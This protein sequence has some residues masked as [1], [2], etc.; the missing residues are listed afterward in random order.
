MLPL[1]CFGI[2][3]ILFTKF[4]S[5]YEFSYVSIFFTLLWLLF[6]IQDLKSYRRNKNDY[7]PFEKRGFVSKVKTFALSSIS[8]L[9]F[10]AVCFAEINRVPALIYTIYKGTHHDL[11]IDV[12]KTNPGGKGSCSGTSKLKFEFT[13]YDPFFGYCLSDDK[14]EMFPDKNSSATFDVIESPVGILFYDV[15]RTAS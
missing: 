12:V 4:L 6:L 9:I 2:D 5:K 15:K 1:V 10:G 7:N 8:V 11:V 14:N 13:H 3:H